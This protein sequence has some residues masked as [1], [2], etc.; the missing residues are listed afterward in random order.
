MGLFAGAMLS[1]IVA[2]G[3]ISDAQPVIVVQP[4]KTCYVDFIKVLKEDATLLNKQIEIYQEASFDQRDLAAQFDKKLKAKQA[5][6]KNE[7][8]KTEKYA[9]LMEE[10]IQLNAKYTDERYDIELN[11][12]KDVNDQAKKRFNELR[13]YAIDIAEKHG[14][15][16][17][18]VISTDSFDKMDFS[19]MQKALMLSP[20]L[21]YTA[22]Y[23]ITAELKARADLDRCNHETEKA[24]AVE[25]TGKEM[26]KLPEDKV[27]NPD[28]IDYEIALGATLT[29]RGEYSD[30]D[31]ATSKRGPV[32]A[33]AVVPFWNLKGMDSGDI[34][35]LPN[36]DAEYTAP[37]EQ[38]KGGPAAGLIVE[39][40]VA[41]DKARVKSKVLRVRILPAPPKDK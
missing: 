26:P 1:T 14:A 2:Q 12:Q 24:Y 29:L 13:K 34:K 4:E 10:I 6:I 30:I 28:R 7:P 41:P 36:F 39:I 11:M 8:P 5:D 32:A 38:P 18:L 27:K 3:T 35:T 17:V 19:D 22:G 20:V 21:H 9:K 37:A 15:T 16:Q 31:K 33:S 40:E 23:D 25:A